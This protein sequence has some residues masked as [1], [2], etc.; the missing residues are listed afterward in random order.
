[1]APLRVAAIG[2]GRI[3][4]FHARHL[5]EI[6]AETGECEL[7]AVADRHGKTAQHIAAELGKRQV[8]EIS[9]FNSAEELAAAG[10]ASAA[11]I[12]SRTED[13]ERDARAC[14][15]SG[16]RV[17]LEKPLA[18][19]LD[20]ARALDAWL[21]ESEERRRSVMLAFQRR[22]DDAL[23][24][25]RK[26]LQ[27]E[28]IGRLFKIVSI[29]EDPEP[30]PKGYQSAGLLVDMGVHNADEVIWMS[31][32]EPTRVAGV[33]ARLHNQKLPDVTVEDFDDA[34]VQLWFGEEMTAQIQVSRNHVAGYRNETFFYGSAGFIH[35][36]AFRGD[37]K[38]VEVALYGRGQELLDSHSFALRDYGEEAPVFIQRFGLA[39]KAEIIDFVQRCR[40]GELFAVTHR[41]GLRAIEVVAAS[42]ESLREA[43]QALCVILSPRP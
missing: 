33:G 14:V 4:V 1:M 23:L 19:D 32:Q 22:Y 12:A 16:M 37:P 31:G 6:G 27:E 9:H 40:S 42:A 39:Y 18:G 35:V 26:W 7:V 3:G 17:L 20:S 15:G 41:D 10:V 21:E 13:H 11:L 5:Q 30:P 34:L 24:Q 28:R 25:T 43:S 29:L 36:G 38:T 8:G 2:V